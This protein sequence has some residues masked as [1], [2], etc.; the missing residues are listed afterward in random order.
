MRRKQHIFCSG[1]HWWQ[2]CR[3]AKPEM[4][5]P[6]HTARRGGEQR[7][8]VLPESQ[9][10]L[11]NPCRR[12]AGLPPR[13]AEPLPQENAES[14]ILI[15]V[16]HTKHAQMRPFGLSMRRVC[17]LLAFGGGHLSHSPSGKLPSHRLYRAL[18]FCCCPVPSGLQPG[19]LPW[20]TVSLLQQR[21]SGVGVCTHCVLIQNW[22]PS[23]PSFHHAA[24]PLWKDCWANYETQL[25]PFLKNPTLPLRHNSHFY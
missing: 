23:V 11:P 14:P 12:G 22:E 6:C 3:R 25:F 5:W 4:D 9:V 21:W 19:H 8:P 24:L 13:S 18:P 2:P 15:L 17:L 10:H 7:L 1:R 20:L 16:Q